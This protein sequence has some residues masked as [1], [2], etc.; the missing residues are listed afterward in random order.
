MPHRVADDGLNPTS[1]LAIDE[2][3]VAGKDESQMVPQ[4]HGNKGDYSYATNSEREREYSLRMITV[5]SRQVVLIFKL[6]QGT[7]L[8]HPILQVIRSLART[9]MQST[10]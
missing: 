6:F 2:C 9:W 7:I 8:Q 10:N 1:D 5:T 3:I 4:A